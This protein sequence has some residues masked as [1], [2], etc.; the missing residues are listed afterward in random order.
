MEASPY[1]SKMRAAIEVDTLTPCR[2]K[3]GSPRTTPLCGT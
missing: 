3:V 2:K 1:C